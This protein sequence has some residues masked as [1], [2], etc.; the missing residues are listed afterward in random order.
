M[1]EVAL[2]AAAT[3]VDITVMVVTSNRV[4][5]V[6][7]VEE[8]DVGHISDDEVENASAPDTQMHATHDDPNMLSEMKASLPTQEEKI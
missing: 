6:G 4:V 1:E 8:L 2:V 3:E 7:E 5:L